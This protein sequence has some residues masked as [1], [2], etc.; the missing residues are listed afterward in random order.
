MHI[1]KK[2]YFI[3]FLNKFPEKSQRLGKHGALGGGGGGD[4]PGD[5]DEKKN[6][7]SIV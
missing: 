1:S 5:L 2:N 4:A 3:I 6:F 7:Y